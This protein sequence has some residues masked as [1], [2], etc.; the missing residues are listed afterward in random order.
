MADD[1]DDDDDGGFDAAGGVEQEE[2]AHEEQEAAGAVAAADVAMQFCWHDVE[3]HRVRNHMLLAGVPDEE[4]LVLVQ[5]DV[6]EHV[7]QRLEVQKVSP[8]R[9]RDPGSLARG[10]GG[11]AAEPWASASPSWPDQA[12]GVVWPAWCRCTR[13]VPHAAPCTL[14]STTGPT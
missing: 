1:D 7:R 10:P 11:Q 13:R 4:L 3:A 14:A 9:R 6:T 5:Y 8:R 2:E 12:P